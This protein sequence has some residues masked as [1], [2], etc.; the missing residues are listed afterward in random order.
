MP[1]Q[2]LIAQ[3]SDHPDLYKEKY[4]G[5]WAVKEINKLS[6]LNLKSVELALFFYLL[7]KG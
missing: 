3:F 1:T 5:E 2:N 7:H 4:E 6:S